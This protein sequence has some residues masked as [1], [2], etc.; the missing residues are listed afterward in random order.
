[1]TFKHKLAVR[2]ALLFTMGFWAVS[3][4]DS[5]MSPGA[6]PGGPT[7]SAAL[8]ATT[9]ARVQSLGANIRSTPSVSG[10]LLGNHPSGA[11]GTI[12]GGPITDGSGDGLTRWQID[13]DSG[14]DGWAADGYFTVIS[15][16]A[17]GS[18]ASVTVSR[19]SGSIAPGAV[20][21]LAATLKDSAGNV[22]SGQSITWS[23]SNASIASVNASGLVSGLVA[24]ST[25]T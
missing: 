14:V 25:T 18:A 15:V 24:G 20:L 2:I 21:Q 19:V 11:L 1:M 4:N 22:L 10:T 9:G 6:T 13:F 12:I 5:P 17:Q 23:S 16:P 8:T 7:V 3:C